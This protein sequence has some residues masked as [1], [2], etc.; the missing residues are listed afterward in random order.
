MRQRQE[1]THQ[2]QKP[3]SCIHARP[4]RLEADAMDHLER[5]HEV[6]EQVTTQ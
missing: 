3:K 2:I 1:L 4:L 6:S 5:L